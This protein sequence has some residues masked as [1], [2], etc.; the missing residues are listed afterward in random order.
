MSTTS[1]EKPINGFS[2]SKQR[3][4]EAILEARRIAGEQEGRDAAEVEGIKDWRVHDIRRTVATGLAGLGTPPHVLSAILNHS[5]GRTQGIT[6][7]YNRFQYAQERR[8]ALAAWAEHVLS[9]TK[10]SG[11]LKIASGA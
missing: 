11:S 4:D 3:L 1:G 2:K 8:E 5:P 10:E 7:V 6:A 9:L